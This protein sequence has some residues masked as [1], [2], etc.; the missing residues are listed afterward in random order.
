MTSWGIF[1]N[2]VDIIVCVYGTASDSRIQIMPQVVSRLFGGGINI[3]GKTFNSNNDMVGMVL[4]FSMN[5]M[6]EGWRSASGYSP[7][8]VLPD[9]RMNLLEALTRQEDRSFLCSDGWQKCSMVLLVTTSTLP[10]SFH[11]INLLLALI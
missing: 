4:A 9:I 5:T 3:A 10:A 11:P 1:N 6:F 8:Y 2:C 7:A